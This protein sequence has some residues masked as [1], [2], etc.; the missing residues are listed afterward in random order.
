[1]DSEM[2]ECRQGRGKRGS[3][4]GAVLGGLRLIDMPNDCMTFG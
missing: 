1:M 3:G 4:G 2:N